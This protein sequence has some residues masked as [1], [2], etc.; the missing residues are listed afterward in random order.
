MNRDGYMAQGRVAYRRGRIILPG[1]IAPRCWQR[2]AFIAG[3]TAE[4]AAWREANPAA[5]EW[6]EAAKR[7]AAFCRSML[8]GEKA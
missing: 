2:R 6:E 3:Y 7:S 8:R 1:T 5:D 4:R